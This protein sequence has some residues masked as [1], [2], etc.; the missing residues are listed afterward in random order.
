MDYIIKK[1]KKILFKQLFIS[2][3]ICMALPAFAN[4]IEKPGRGKGFLLLGIYLEADA[5]MV[6]KKIG[7]SGARNLEW[8]LTG[9]NT[10]VL[11]TLPKGKYQILEIKVP[12]FNLPY[13]KY[14]ADNPLWRFEIEEG[15]VNYIGKLE[16]EKQRTT[17]Y[18]E[19]KR[20]NRIIT[21]YDEIK[22]SF[23]EL[24]LSYPL[25]NG[26]AIRDDFAAEHTNGIQQD[27]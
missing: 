2:C 6:I 18:A 10:W 16:V 15:K 25:V 1:T 24:L 26:M 23:P 13:R 9:Q 5:A 8:P 12:Y 19:I 7:T 22:T 27:E 4:P 11:K 3:V 21:D 17:N 14:T 20:L